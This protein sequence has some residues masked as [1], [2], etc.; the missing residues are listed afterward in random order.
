MSETLFPKSVRGHIDDT[1][2]KMRA[3]LIDSEKDDKRPLV[4]RMLQHHVDSGPGGFSI[5]N[6]VSECMG[7]LYVD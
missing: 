3:A 1:S 7:H 2:A 5:Q 6:I 4:Q